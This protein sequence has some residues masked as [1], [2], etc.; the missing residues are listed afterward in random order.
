[1]GEGGREGGRK[2]EVGEGGREGGSGRWEREGGREGG[3]KG[4]VGEGGSMGKIVGGRATNGVHV[5]ET[6]TCI[7]VHRCR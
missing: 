1:M 4:E 6:E 3:R 7:H 2:W 5:V